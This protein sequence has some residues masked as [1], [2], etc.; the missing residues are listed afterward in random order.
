[1]DNDISINIPPK[2]TYSFQCVADLNKWFQSEL[3]RR[4]PEK[5]YFFDMMKLQNKEMFY[6]WLK[7]EILK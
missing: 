2:E 4:Y 5:D 6:E 3:E 1:M 7:T